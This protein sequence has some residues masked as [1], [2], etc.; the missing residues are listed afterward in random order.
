MPEKSK[1]QTKQSVNQ[2]TATMT[3]MADKAKRNYEQTMRTGM[4]L[5]EEAGRWWSQTWNQAAM[6]QEWQKRLAEFTQMASGLAPLAQKRMQEMMDMMETNS[7]T[8]AE[9]IR[10]ATDAAQ[11]FGPD[12]QSKWMEFW[13]SSLG[14]IRTNIEAATE[15]NTRAIDSWI[16]YVRKNTAATEARMA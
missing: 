16:N 6:A 1:S 7:R 15:F 11:S 14:A 3:D 13:V 8:S 9:L 4:K 10:K 12:G 2:A 5:Q